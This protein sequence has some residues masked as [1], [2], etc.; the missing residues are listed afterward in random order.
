[1]R[2]A[3]CAIALFAQL[4]FAELHAQRVNEQQASDERLAFAQNQLDDFCRLHH[5]YEPR[6]DTKH[7]AFGT[8]W[9]ES[10]RWRLGIEAAIARTSFCREHARRPCKPEYRTVDLRLTGDAAGVVRVVAGGGVVT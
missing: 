8:G 9:H 2:T 5:A 1:L 10:R 7:S 3:G 4:E 6:Q